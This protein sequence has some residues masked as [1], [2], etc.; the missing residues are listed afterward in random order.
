MIDR[1]LASTVVAN[2]VTLIVPLGLLLLTI[3]LLIWLLHGRQ[4]RLK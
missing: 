3:A 4:D 1:L 2:E